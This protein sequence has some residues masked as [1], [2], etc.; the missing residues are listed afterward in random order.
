MRTPHIAVGNG[1]QRRSILLRS[2]MTFATKL[3][4]FRQQRSRLL[5]TQ[6]FIMVTKRLLQLVPSMYVLTSS[7]VGI[8]PHRNLLDD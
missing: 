2:R 8:R 4:I 3:W 6:L 1:L 7:Q 5:S